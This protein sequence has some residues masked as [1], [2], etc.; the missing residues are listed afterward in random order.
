VPERLRGKVALIT[1]GARGMG[2]SHG[3]LFAEEGATVVLADVRDDLGEEAAMTFGERGLLVSYVHLDVTVSRD[4]AEAIATTERTH[5]RLDVLVNNAGIIS[6]ADAV[7]ESEETWAQVIAVNQTGVF[8]GI[9]H[10]VPAM[11]RSGG[12]SIVNISSIVGVVGV[13]DYIAYQASKGA[14]RLMSRSAALSYAKD[15]IRV[16]TV[17]PGVVDTDMFRELPR[18]ITDHDIRAT[19]LGRAGRPRDVSFGV[20]YLASDE[21][22]FVTGAEPPIDGG[23]VPGL[24]GQ[25]TQ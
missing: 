14:V 24:V 19:S 13:E 10:A 7:E 18:Q 20:L 11:R 23:Y 3:E 8:L 9:K 1:G 25:G 16:N 21:S 5:G 4:W 15:G 6:D 2:A 22:S 17:C 12:G